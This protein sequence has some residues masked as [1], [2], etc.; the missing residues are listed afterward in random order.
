MQNKIFKDKTILITGGTGSIGSGILEALVEASVTK[1][2][3]FSRDEYK[4]HRLRYK[5][6]K[7][8]NIEYILGDVRDLEALH[9]ASKGADIIFHAA[10]YK[11]VPMSEEMPE[12]FIKTNILG[13]LNVKK[14]AVTNGIPL[15]VSISTDKAANPSNVMGL[16]KALQEKIFSSYYLQEGNKGTK[17]V[18]VRFGNVIGTAGSFFPI[19]YHQIKNK[20]PITIT[21]SDMTR[22]FMSKDE[23]IELIFWAAENGDNGSTVIR[24]MKATTVNLLVKKF[25]EIL[26]VGVD[27]PIKIIGTRVGEKQHE[28][29]IS[30]DESFRIKEDKQ[31]YI[32]MPYTTHQISENLVKGS[33]SLISLIDKFNSSTPENQLNDNE[34]TRYVKRFINSQKG[35]KQ[36]I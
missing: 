8:K 36:F 20:Q 5:Y 26:N 4:Q 21:N 27:Y 32:V 31:Y 13:S 17:F 3:I 7:Y 14:T 25:F 16:T 24:R 34:L 28:T 6:A 30:E 29:L 15:V 19:L 9:Y 33:P 12:E 22:F 2:K 18:N 23:A 1:I 35:I 11:H 10:A